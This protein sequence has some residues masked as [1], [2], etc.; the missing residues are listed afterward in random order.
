MILTVSTFFCFY[1][2]SATATNVSAQINSIPMLNGTNF[3]IW[4]ENVEIVLG[5]LDLDLALRMERH[6]STRKTPMMLKLRSGIVPI[7]FV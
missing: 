1:S 2:V 3:K 5:C 6:T 7:T 4:L